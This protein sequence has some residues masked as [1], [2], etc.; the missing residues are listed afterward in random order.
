MSQLWSPCIRELKPYVPGEQSSSATLIKLNTNENPYGP[1]PS[2]LAALNG[3][4]GSGLRLYPDPDAAKLKQ[5]IASYYHVTPS[6]VFVGNGSDEVLAHAF[7]AFFI[8]QQ[9]ILFPDITYSFY[10]V[11]CKLYGIAFTTVALDSDM[12]LRVDDYQQSC[13]GIVLANP[14]APTGIA[15]PLSEIEKCVRAHPECVVLVDEAYVDFGGHTAM[16]LVQKYPNLLI[17]QTFSK[18]RSL[19]GLR[20]GFAVG[21]ASL[22]EGLERV[23]NSFNSYPLGR[24]AIAGAVAAIEDE[25]YFQA[26]R[27]QLM[28]TR[29]VL[30]RQ[31]QAMGFLVCPSA[32][33]FLFVRHPDHDAASLAAAPRCAH[34]RSWSATSASPELKIIYASASALTPNARVCR[35]RW[36]SS[37][38]SEFCVRTCAGVAAKGDG[39]RCARKRFFTF[40]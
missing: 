2:V 6:E 12:R 14:N 28:R 30:A 19:A 17:V 21:D 36:P 32:T 25:D 4:V 1:S 22:I 39:W 10:P 18:S 7:H 26:T 31:L 40:A 38:A 35:R 27:R 8:Q 23:K 5:A 20:V 11:Y 15:S 16:A 33:N 13:G 29:D 37:L 34:A 9:P 3:E 24:L